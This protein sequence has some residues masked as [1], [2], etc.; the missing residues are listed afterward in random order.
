ME[1]M[2]GPTNLCASTSEF[3]CPGLQVAA[4]KTKGGHNPP[5]KRHTTVTL[6]LLKSECKPTN[7]MV[8]ALAF[9]CG[10]HEMK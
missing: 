6:S 10:I 1:P 3:R 4:Q 5:G 2:F 9:G 8:Y 7:I